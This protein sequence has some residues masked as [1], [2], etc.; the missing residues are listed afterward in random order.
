MRREPLP[1]TASGFSPWLAALLAAALSVVALVLLARGRDRLPRDH[2]THRSLHERPVSRV[3][4]LAI[5]AGFVPVALLFPSPV[6]GGPIWLFALAAVIGVSVADDWIGVRPVIRL[7][8]QALAALAVAAQL[9]GHGTGAGPSP[10]LGLAMAVAALAIVWSAN[11]FN[12]MDGNDGLAALMSICGF[13]ALG[14]AAM[15]AGIYADAYFAL[16][17][18]SAVFL[19]VNAPPART[20]MGDGGSVGLGFL[21]AVFGLSGIVSQSWPGW[22]PLL[23]FLPFLADATVTVVRRLRRGDHLFEAHRTHYYQRLHR[24]GFGHLGTLLVYGVLIVG[25]ATSALYALA[26]APGAGWR[27]LGAWILAIG[28]FFAGID[29]HWRRRSQEQE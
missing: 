4:G 26:L 17:S 29:Y 19:A 8:V 12:F 9:L 28:A 2:P 22:F 11:L 24:L 10:A 3:G 27:V 18:A 6:A 23:V 16:A 14:I 15:R 13:G 21:A 25:T 20:F 1:V 7:G 5:W